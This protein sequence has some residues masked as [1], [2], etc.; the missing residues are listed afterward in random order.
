MLDLDDLP[1]SPAKYPATETA[2][3]TA[4]GASGPTS[5]VIDPTAMHTAQHTAS[6][7]RDAQ[8]TKSTTEAHAIPVSSSFL[9]PSVASTM[10][11][12]QISPGTITPTL[13]GWRED[14]AL[15]LEAQWPASTV[16]GRAGGDLENPSGDFGGE[17]EDLS[18]EVSEHE[19]SPALPQPRKKTSAAG[20][21]RSGRQ[22]VTRGASA[23]AGDRSQ[24]L[25][26]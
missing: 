25:K 16:L 24:D 21:S 2:V 20:G 7:A 15:S 14:T 5:V 9:S 10:G 6:Q 18:P 4:S 1:R 3:G 12:A 22:P 11:A 23:V 19:Q 13:I 26:G 8:G 17:S